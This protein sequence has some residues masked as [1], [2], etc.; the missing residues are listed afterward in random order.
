MSKS[1]P[2]FSRILDVKAVGNAVK[3]YKLIA[4]PEE[5]KA[6][7]KRFGILKIDLFEVVYSVEQIP[8][9][10]FK[11]SGQL[12]AKVEQECVATNKPVK[13][14]VGEEF[15][16]VLRPKHPGPKV[17]EDLDLSALS[18]EEEEEIEI[19]A[20]GKIDMGEVFTQYFSLS[21][22]PYPR[23]KGAEFSH[24]KPDTPT[25]ENPFDVLKDLK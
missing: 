9:K 1:I 17:K 25:K 19:P 20:S 14:K 16:V 11:I 10:S 21:L 6:L 3:E 8:N 18:T 4:K 13:E 22:N 24:K 12:K 15:H 7:T 5:R 23:Y 2:E